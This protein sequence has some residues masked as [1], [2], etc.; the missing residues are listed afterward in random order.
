MKD[1]LHTV[2]VSLGHE[3][4]ERGDAAAAGLY[5]FLRTYK[6]IATL[7][8]FCDV[9]PTVNILSKTLQKAE[10]DFSLVNDALQTTIKVLRKRQSSDGLCLASI[11]A[12]IGQLETRAGCA[13]IFST[14]LMN[15]RRD[16]DNAT[17]DRHVAAKEAFDNSIK[18]PLVEKLIDNI[19]SRFTSSDTMASFTIFN[20]A[21]LP[22]EEI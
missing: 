20:P 2:I 19:E 1:I 22:K 14:G 15:L 17:D 16:L 21:N 7:L 4:E 9:L 13:V 12:Y 10:L 11:D 5:N 18:N 6:F 3:S 8:L